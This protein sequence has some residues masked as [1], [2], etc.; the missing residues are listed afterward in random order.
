MQVIERDVKDHRSLLKHGPVDCFR[1][2]LC[3]SKSMEW[4]FTDFSIL[5]YPCSRL[6]CTLV[7]SASLA[8]PSSATLDQIFLA[9]L[10]HMDNCSAGMVS[11]VPDG[12][13]SKLQVQLQTA[14]NG[15]NISKSLKIISKNQIRKKERWSL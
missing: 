9:Q 5:P 4:E 12:P 14:T 6:E 15:F 13:L 11:E 8:L 3:A 1:K 7:G 2:D 10:A